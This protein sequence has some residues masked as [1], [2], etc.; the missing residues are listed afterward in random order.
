MS[1]GI[2][3]DRVRMGVVSERD[4]C[5]PVRMARDAETDGAAR[6]YGG[7]GGEDWKRRCGS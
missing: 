5:E 4:V 1:R 7:G 6:A 3:K 2:D